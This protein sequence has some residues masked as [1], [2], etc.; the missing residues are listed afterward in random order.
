MLAA[1]H[2]GTQINPA[3]QPNRSESS[4]FQDEKIL[5]LNSFV[6]SLHPRAASIYKT[7]VR[8][9]WETSG[10]NFSG[11]ETSGRQQLGDKSDTSGGQ[12][13]DKRDKRRQVGEKWER[14]K[15]GSRGKMGNKWET[16]AKKWETSRTQ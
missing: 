3:S 14:E 11:G 9:K 15:R 1:F 8:N 6:S 16:S 2:H 4:E 13:G 10:N 12:A 7:S 5:G